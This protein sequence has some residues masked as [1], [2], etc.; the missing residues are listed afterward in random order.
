MTIRVRSDVP[1]LRTVRLVREIERS[2]RETLER[3]RFR[4]THYSIQH[5]HLHL[6]VEAEDASASTR[7]ETRTRPIRSRFTTAG[8]TGLPSASPETTASCGG[9]SIW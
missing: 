7:V 4:V 3:K 8:R 6:L 2:L 9:S 5:D 1:S